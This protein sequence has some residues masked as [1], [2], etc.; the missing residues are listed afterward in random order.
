MQGECGVGCR[1]KVEWG[2]GGRWRGAWFVVA[3]KPH[4]GVGNK[5]RDGL[6]VVVF[7]C[8]LFS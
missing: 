8:L 3:A 6:Q 4:R 2:A 7:V 1:G 5:R